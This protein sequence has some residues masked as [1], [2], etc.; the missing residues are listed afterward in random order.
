MQPALPLHHLSGSFSPLLIV[1]LFPEEFV[2]LMR[3][4]TGAL[5]MRGYATRT[6]RNG[7]CCIWGMLHL[8][9]AA[10]GAR[11][12]TYLSFSD[13]FLLVIPALRFSVVCR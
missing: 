5:M 11:T 3:A 7:A 4:E 1:W 2:Y 12:P 13:F 9:H 10:F 8:G 6:C